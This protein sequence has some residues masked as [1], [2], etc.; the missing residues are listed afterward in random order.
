MTNE[1]L[2]SRGVCD[3][4]P[5]N[6]PNSFLIRLPIAPVDNEILEFGGNII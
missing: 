6:K 5:S 1:S 3:L 2:Q 4:V